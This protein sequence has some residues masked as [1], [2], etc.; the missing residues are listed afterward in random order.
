MVG[1]SRSSAI[2]K[3]ENRVAGHGA[4]AG[5]I[6]PSIGHEAGVAEQKAKREI[7]AMVVESSND[8]GKGAHEHIVKSSVSRAHSPA[9][10][11]LL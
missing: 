5:S 10:F 7:G 6:F 4:I 9:L 2:E 3:V 8:G 11:L 1:C